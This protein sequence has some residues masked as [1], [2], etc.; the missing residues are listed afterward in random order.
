V[1]SLGRDDVTLDLH[2]LGFNVFF[3]VI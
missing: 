2:R 3:Y 1:C